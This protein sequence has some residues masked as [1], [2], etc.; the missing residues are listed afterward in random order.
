MPREIYLRQQHSTFRGED[1]TLGGLKE[2]GAISSDTRNRY[3]QA[4]YYSL[5][6]IKKRKMVMKNKNKNRNITLPS[7]IAH[8]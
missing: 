3:W 7:H 6:N 8:F 2:D 5:K 4:K 1:E